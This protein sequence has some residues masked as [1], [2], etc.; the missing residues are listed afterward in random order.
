MRL[1]CRLI[2]STVVVAS[3]LGLLP[4]A[5]GGMSPSSAKRASGS[6]PVTPCNVISLQV[7]TPADRNESSRRDP[8]FAV[9]LML[10]LLGIK[11]SPFRWFADLRIR[12]KLLV[13]LSLA[14][15]T[16]VATAWIGYDAT[17]RLTECTAAQSESRTG[18]MALLARMALLQHEIGSIE[19]AIIGPVP[20]TTPSIIEQCTALENRLACGE[21]LGRQ[22]KALPI[23]PA[24]EREQIHAA[25]DRRQVEDRRFLSLALRRSHLLAVGYGPA[26][27]DVRQLTDDLRAAH[28]ASMQ[29]AGVANAAVGTLIASVN[30]AP[31]A[32][33][34][35][36]DGIARAAQHGII[37]V[38][39]A[40]LTLACCAGLWT[41]RLLVRPIRR[42]VLL[43]EGVMQGETGRRIDDGRRDEIG[44][45]ASAFNGILDTASSFGEENRRV[46]CAASGGDLTVRGD[47]SQFR[48]L[49]AD[50]TRGINVLIS[51]T[52]DGIQDATARAM[53]L[54]WCGV[55]GNSQELHA[56]NWA[57][58]H[59]VLS[60]IRSTTQ[61]AIRV[62]DEF[63]RGDFQS[64]PALRDI[65]RQVPDDVI[66]PLLLRIGEA[67]LRMTADMEAEAWAL[68]GGNLSARLDE[69]R[70]QGEFRTMV[71]EL[72]LGLESVAGR[73]NRAVAVAEEV[74]RRSAA[75]GDVDSK[76]HE[77]DSLLETLREF[78]V[79]MQYEKLETAGPEP[80]DLASE[81]LQ[82][83]DEHGE[84]ATA[85]PGGQTP[86]AAP[87]ETADAAGRK[88]KSEKSDSL[89]I[90]TP[91]DQRK[92][93]EHAA[94]A[95]EGVLWDKGTTT[96]KLGE[97]DAMSALLARLAS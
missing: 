4:M 58:L 24:L 10:G 18:E 97:T 32:T 76:E 37:I 71:R 14:G 21:V 17:M 11:R 91:R 57:D 72:N 77:L 6:D 1:H 9:P 56:D 2:C 42:L 90:I 75:N 41:A 25:W 59:Q 28:A 15:G 94:R 88:E 13:V 64:L 82:F 39:G 29:N 86:Q 69:E 61:L 38:L 80:H 20:G 33:R 66:A 87:I 54:G 78:A 51:T 93:K 55:H 67:L 79:A 62:L 5:G 36:G 23:G 68:S 70:H 49:Y 81:E 8:A 96:W 44:A 27:H 26:H 63:G 47:V 31:P 85:S 53:A 60:R 65:V 43:A 84:T 50:L 45:L 83:G 48:G 3:C 35:D 16:A 46:L 34:D 7:P 30:N 89:Q 92:T 52:A 40:G 12:T 19:D 95:E 73:M 74:S 22:F